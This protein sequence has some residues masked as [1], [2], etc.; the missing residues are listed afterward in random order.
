MAE[1]KEVLHTLPLFSGLDPQDL[2]LLAGLFRLE[3][4]SAGT[5]IFGQGD[6]AG[7]LYVLLYGKVEIRFKPHDGE[8]LTVTI[9][10]DGGVFGWSAAL[11]RK[12]YTSCAVSIEDSQVLHTEG[13]HLRELIE[14]HPNTGIVIL[15]RLAT[16]IAERL[17][18]THAQVK[19]LLTDGMR[20]D[21]DG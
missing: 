18:N 19:S 1:I 12:E 11:G 8:T 10:D 5:T 20:V 2:D 13:R 14:K 7:R 21:I 16:V 15:D 9:L 6:R 4:Y 17:R 3:S